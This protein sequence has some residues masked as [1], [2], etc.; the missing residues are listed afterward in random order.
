MKGS[1]AKYFSKNR[2]Y[3]V[4][5]R[6]L[7]QSVLQ[8]NTVPLLETGG[9]GEGGVCMGSVEGELPSDFG[10]LQVRYRNRDRTGRIKLIT[11]YILSFLPECKDNNVK[12]PFWASAGECTRD[13]VWMLANCRR[14]CNQCGGKYFQ[15]PGIWWNTPTSSSYL[16]SVHQFRS[17]RGAIEEPLYGF[18]RRNR[19][20]SGN[21]MHAV[22]TFWGP[23]KLEAHK[24]C[25]TAAERF[26][27]ISS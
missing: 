22:A 2:F 13:R 20:G 18:F 16:S 6:M 23:L 4:N 27:P 1:T 7:R 24:S 26:N 15:I 17:S 12:C 19:T 14:S 5:S 11:R 3:V 9:W 10:I 21:E 8:R 25:D